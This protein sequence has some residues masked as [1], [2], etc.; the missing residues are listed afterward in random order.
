MEFGTGSPLNIPDVSV[1]T[2][3][4]DRLR[5]NWTIGYTPNFVV[6]TWVGNNDNTPM[7]G[8]ASGITG[9]A[10]IWRSVFVE[11]LTKNPAQKL[12]RPDNVIEKDCIGRKELFIK[13]TENFVNCTYVPPSPSATPVEQAKSQ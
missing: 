9:A 8:I 11:L 2:G 12:P 7:S 3:T 4:S 1:K 5:D 6:A 13:G 10:P